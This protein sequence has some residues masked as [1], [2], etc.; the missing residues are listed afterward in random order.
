MKTINTPKVVIG[1]SLESVLFASRNNCTL[2]LNKISPPEIYEAQ[3][4]ETWNQVT[5]LLSMAGKIPMSDKVSTIRI[6]EE[7]KK[8]KVFT[9][10][11]R[12]IEFACEEV[13]V[14]DDEN[15]EGLPV[16]TTKHKNPKKKILDWVNVRAGMLH[17]FQ[18]IETGDEFV[19]E[20]HFYKSP[21]I[22]GDHEH[23]DLV[24][25]SYLTDE[26]IKDHSY[27]DLMTLY[28]T[29]EVM[30]SHGI[31]GPRNGKDPNN[32]EKYKY[33][34]IKLEMNRRQIKKLHMDSYKG[35]N[36]I[37]FCKKD[38]YTEKNEYISKLHNYIG[39]GA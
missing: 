21:R 2:I 36:F 14:F 16:P 38:T 18:F 39:G 23:K 34:D 3:E 13:F 25:I 19:S 8:I 1:S 37:S 24:V 31:K 30:K 26:Q 29:K 5:F 32:P 27:S 7:D 20:L 28:K 6:I 11:N 9:S 12:M 33:Y 22:D 17:E 15:V 4:L 35:T 10:S